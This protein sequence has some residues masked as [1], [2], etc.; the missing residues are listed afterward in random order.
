M[1]SEATKAIKGIAAEVRGD[2][3]AYKAVVS[4]LGGGG[5]AYYR[6]NGRWILCSYDTIPSKTYRRLRAELM[7]AVR[8]ALPKI[9]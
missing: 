9:S 1:A 4:H 2:T 7:Q 6:F 8:A 5:T 3:F